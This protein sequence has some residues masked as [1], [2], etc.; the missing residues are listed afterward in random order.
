MPSQSTCTTLTSSLCPSNCLMVLPEFKSHKHTRPLKDPVKARIVSQCTAIDITAE[1]PPSSKSLT[2]SPSR[3]FQSLKPPSLEPDNAN[4]KRGSRVPHARCKEAPLE[5]TLLSWSVVSFGRVSAHQSSCCDATGTPRLVASRS[6][7][8]LTF[9]SGR[10][11]KRAK[12]RPRRFRT[13]ICNAPSGT[14]TA[15]SSLFTVGALVGAVDTRLRAT[16][17]AFSCLSI[18]GMSIGTLWGSSC[19]AS[20]NRAA[21]K[22][23]GSSG[24]SRKSNSNNACMNSCNRCRSR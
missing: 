19:A 8:A 12:L 13:T 16:C 6:F 3:M 7:T 2:N 18:M 23:Y 21:M 5:G 15:A 1:E 4:L 17:G 11:A 20:W 10:T 22:A 14:A 24:R 9:S